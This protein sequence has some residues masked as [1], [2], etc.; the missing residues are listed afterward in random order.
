MI[1]SSA[2]VLSAIN[3]ETNTQWAK[4]R[5]GNHASTGHG[6]A[7]EDYNALCDKISGFHVKS[8]GRTNEA[9]GSDRIVDGVHIQVKYCS[10][11]YATVNAAFEN[12]G[13]GNY[14]YES[15][16]GPQILEVPSDQYEECLRIM[17]EKIK[18]GKVKNIGSKSAKDIVKKGSC[19]YIQAKNIARAGNIDSLLFDITTGS[20]IAL[21]SFGVSF[22]VKLA[23]AARSCKSLDDFKMAIQLSFLDGLRSGTI[24]LSTSVFTSQIIRT[25]FGRNFVTLAQHLSKDSIDTFYST[26]IGKKLIHDI[27]S[28]MWQKCL[29][30]ASAKN[31]VIKLVRVNAVT[32]SAVFLIT[33]IPDTY[34]FLVSKSISGKQFMKNLVV[35][36]SSIT[37]ATVGGL[38]GM[39]FGHPG[40]IVGGFIGG[41]LSGILSKTITNRIAKDDSEHMQELIKIALLELANEYSIQSQSEFDAVIRNIQID[42]AIDTDLIRAMYSIGHEN[43]NDAIRVDFAKV[44][45]CYHFDVI[46]RQRKQ[47]NLIGNE[48][49]IIDAINDINV[50]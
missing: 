30:G 16:N 36:A 6:F 22:C 7:A 33:S 25:Q 45:L 41:A 37:G 35:N 15:V 20:V 18:S 5:C 23:L 2:G 26:P 38:L 32:N 27:A 9:N 40:A 19:T 43:N 31:T 34:R 13:S 12:N 28:G 10:S 8:S 3:I 47:V 48:E 1:S 11:P 39:K 21:S 50:E 4:Y 44:A 46:A 14:R 17:D 42:K 29:T 49:I 24:T